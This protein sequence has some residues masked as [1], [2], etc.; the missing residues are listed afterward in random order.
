MV[1]L[2]TCLVDK[3]SAGGGCEISVT[4]GTDGLSLLN[5]ASYFVK[6]SSKGEKA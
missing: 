4:A 6:M 5:M 3:V 1:Q 2:F